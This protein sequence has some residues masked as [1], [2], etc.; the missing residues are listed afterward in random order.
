MLGRIRLADGEVGGAR[1]RTLLAALLLDTNRMVTVDRLVDALWDAAPPASAIANI[2]THVWT[3]RR[4]IGDAAT[5]VSHPG[6]YELV[7]PENVCDTHVFLLCAGAGRAALA[8][9][10]FERAGGRPATP[11]RPRPRTPRRSPPLLRQH[12]GTTGILRPG[13]DAGGA[14]AA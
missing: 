9:G 1:L 7:V 6:G 12:V 11:G 8:D 3:L 13:A 2:R 5:L 14:A 10:E 4:L